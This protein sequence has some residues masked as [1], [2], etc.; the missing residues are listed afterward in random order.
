MI[1]WL[2]EKGIQFD[3][4]IAFTGPGLVRAYHMTKGSTGQNI[5]KALRKACADNGVESLLRP[6]LRSFL[7]T[8]KER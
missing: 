3:N 6:G 7:R 4:V 1:R 8:K 2:E 5:I